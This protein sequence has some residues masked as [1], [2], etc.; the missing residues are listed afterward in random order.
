LT[1]AALPARIYR[2]FAGPQNLENMDRF[3]AVAAGGALGAMLRYSAYLVA[4]HVYE[5]PAPAATWSVNLLGCLLI[6]FLAPAVQSLGVTANVRLLLLV[7]FLG[8]FT[9]FSTF[10]LESLVLWQEGRLGLVLVNA[11][12][13]VAAGLV[14]VWLGMRLHEGLLGSRVVP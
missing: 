3:I 13:S 5:G 12:G 10:S 1:G 9:T 4:A 8:S 2:Q 14:L 11:V 7:G 6:G